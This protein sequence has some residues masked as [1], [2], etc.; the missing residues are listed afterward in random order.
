MIDQISLSSDSQEL[1][2]L[3][4]NGQHLNVSAIY[5]RENAMDAWTRRERIVNG[6]VVV[7]PA[8]KIDSITPLGGNAVNISFSD[9]HDR[10]IYPYRYLESIARAAD[11]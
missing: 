9:G 11:K 2:I 3:L 8:I 4:S 6:T 7:D 1:E 5:L 10:A